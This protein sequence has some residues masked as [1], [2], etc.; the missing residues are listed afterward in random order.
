MGHQT[1]QEAMTS[2]PTAITPETTVQEAARLMKSEDV[3]ALPIVED[4]R[5][6]CVI[7]DRDLAH[8]RGRGRARHR[9]MPCASWPRRIVV[10]IDP[11]QSL[12]RSGTADGAA[13][14]PAPPG[15][16]RGRPARRDARAGGCRGRGPRHADRRRRRRRSRSR[17]RKGVEMPSR[18]AN[19]K[20]EKQY[21]ALKDKGMSKER[22]A[23]IA[24]SP[25]A[26]KHGGREVRTRRQLSGNDDSSQGGACDH[27]GM[28][29]GCRPQGRQG[30]GPAK[31]LN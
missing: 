23:R 3:G 15:R 12:E 2:N 16:G 29:I 11:Q 21:E 4:G 25:D 20:N 19:V 18:S 1:V 5:L 9:D 6:T 13:P 22:A 24:N 10:T 31:M 7:T 28:K 26:S 14:D 30:D 8:P 17:E 27:R